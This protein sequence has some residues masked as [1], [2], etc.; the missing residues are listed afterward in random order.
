MKIEGIKVS[1]KINYTG[2]RW[3]KLERDV[4]GRT[5]MHSEKDGTLI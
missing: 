5:I 2:Y 1:K 3:R 4:F